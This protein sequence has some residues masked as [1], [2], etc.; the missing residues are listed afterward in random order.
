[1]SG[2]PIIPVVIDTNVLVPSLYSYTPIAHFILSG[3]LV[4]IWNNYIY[5]E[6]CRIIN[7]LAKRY[8]V[9][10][11]VEPGEVIKLFELIS[12][13]GRKVDEMPVDWPPASSDRKDDPFLWAAV[14]GGAEYII[15]D[16]SKH[17][18]KL[19]SFKGIPIGRPENFFRWVEKVHPMTS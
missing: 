2:G 8:H 3:N 1:M 16:D 14:A 6:V 12:F 9:K 17:F 7:R 18:L 10:A 5:R 11:G 19:K 13:A 15:S 4:L